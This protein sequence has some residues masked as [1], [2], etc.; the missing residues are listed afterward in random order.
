MT[1]T[2]VL[3][4]IAGVGVYAVSDALT[5]PRPRLR[6]TEPDQRPLFQRLLDSFFGPAAE[7]V[8]TIGRGDVKQIKHDLAQRLARAN[9]PQPLTSPERVLAYQLFIAFVF[10]ILGELAGINGEMGGTGLLVALA[11]AAVGWM[12]PLQVIKNAEQARREQLMLDAASTMDRLASFVAAGNTLR[13][14]VR[15]IAERPG[16]AWVG[17]FRHIA[18][19]IA[20]SGSF[21]AALDEAMEKSGRLPEIVRVCERL[22]AAHEMG[23]GGVIRAL[24]QMAADARTNVK[25]LITKRGYENAAWMIAPAFLAILA[26]AMLLIAPGA[27]KMMMALSG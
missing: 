23:G 17:E 9:Y 22:R 4:V 10:G 16:G 26:T 19:T 25:N 1:F 3:A 12:V 20:V 11:L 2:I 5:P 27:A 13:A 14:A 7:R 18:S 24:R 21:E 8:I 15:S 6:L